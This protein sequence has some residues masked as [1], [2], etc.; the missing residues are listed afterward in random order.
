LAAAEPVRDPAT[1]STSSSSSR[2]SSCHAG[3]ARLAVQG[4]TPEG[5][6]TLDW[7][8]RSSATPRDAPEI[9]T[10]GRPSGRSHCAS[11]PRSHGRS[12]TRHSGRIR[13]AFS[14]RVLHVD[15]MLGRWKTGGRCRPDYLE[16]EP[17]GKS[18]RSRSTMKLCLADLTDGM[19]GDRQQVTWKEVGRCAMPADARHAEPRIIDRALKSSARA[20][21]R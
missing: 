11:R 21:R 16:N 8:R 15:R 12:L 5:E 10:S 3:A 6:R 9:N 17:L 13:T 1:M 4:F 20:T 7:A 18:A 19:F 2:K 14:Y